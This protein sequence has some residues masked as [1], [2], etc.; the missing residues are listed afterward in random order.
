MAEHQETRE[1]KETRWAAQRVTHD[2]ELHD[3]QAAGRRRTVRHVI[4]AVIVIIVG[5]VGAVVL[6]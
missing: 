4:V 2:K 6:L 3:S 5:V 1:E